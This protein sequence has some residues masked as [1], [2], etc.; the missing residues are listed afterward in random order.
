MLMLM[1]SPTERVAASYVKARDLVSRT[2]VPAGDIHPRPGAAAGTA[3]GESMSEIV[4]RPAAPSASLENHRLR[5]FS[6]GERLSARGTSPCGVRCRV[7]RQRDI[8]HHRV[9]PC[10]AA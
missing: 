2:R 7:K 5:L 10:D 4:R 6:A 8:E 1:K 3:C 9:G